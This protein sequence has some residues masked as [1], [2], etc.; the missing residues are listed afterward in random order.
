MTI[1]LQQLYL[2]ADFQVLTI[3][4]IYVLIFDLLYI[5]HI[6]YLQPADS[7]HRDDLKCFLKDDLLH[8]RYQRWSRQQIEHRSIV[9]MHTNIPLLFQICRYSYFDTVPVNSIFCLDFSNNAFSEFSIF[10][11]NACGMCQCESGSGS[12][13]R[14]RKQAHL[15][16]HC[17]KTLASPVA[18]F[19]PEGARFSPS[20][21]SQFFF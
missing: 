10:P 21:Q 13:M 20:S 17:G 18:P 4:N 5:I 19:H 16:N 12:I 2:Y 3:I 14:T 6:I 11:T 7:S 15:E 8:T 9:Y 1:R